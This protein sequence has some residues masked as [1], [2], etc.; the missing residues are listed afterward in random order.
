MAHKHTNPCSIP[1]DLCAAYKEQTRIV[2][3]LMLRMSEL[4]NRHYG[5]DECR[6]LIELIRGGE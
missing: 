6:D 2:R 3:L 4:Q 5:Y 1:D